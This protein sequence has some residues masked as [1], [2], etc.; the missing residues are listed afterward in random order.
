MYVWKCAG[1]LRRTLPLPVTGYP[2]PLSQ[3]K[4]QRIRVDLRTGVGDLKARANTHIQYHRMK[5]GSNYPLIQQKQRTL[6]C[7]SLFPFLG[8]VVP[9]INFGNHIYGT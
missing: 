8:G 4:V 6:N 7:Y 1:R 5:R 2:C 3:T 9:K